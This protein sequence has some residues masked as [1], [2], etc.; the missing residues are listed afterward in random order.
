MSINNTDD[1]IDSRDV[2][3]RIEELEDLKKIVDDCYER[4]GILISEEDEVKK[5]DAARAD[6][7]AAKEDFSEEEE[8]ELADLQSLAEEASS[9]SDWDIGEMLI[10]DSYFEEY[11]KELASDIGVISEDLN[12]W[13]IRHIDWEEAA[14]ELKQDYIEVDFDGETYWIKR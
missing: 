4:L 1:V 2:I 9:S 5:V 6:L 13:P 14:D 8:V 3:S 10:H 7:E 12:E 11:V